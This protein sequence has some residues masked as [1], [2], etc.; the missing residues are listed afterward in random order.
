MADV[1]RRKQ[2]RKGVGTLWGIFDEAN[3]YGDASSANLPELVNQRS[4]KTR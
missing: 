2:I 4:D 1:R 3:R